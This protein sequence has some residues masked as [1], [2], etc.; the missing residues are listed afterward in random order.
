MARIES[1]WEIVDVKP[2]NDA[3]TSV[4]FRHIEG[5]EITTWQAGQYMTLQVLQDTQWSAAHP[6]TITAPPGEA[7]L[8]A[9]I[10]NVGSFSARMQQVTSGTPARIAGPFGKFCSN[11][12]VKPNIAMIAGGIG[13]TPFLSVL[14]HFRNIH[15]TNT[16]TLFW[17]NNLEQDLFAVDELRELAACLNLTLVF[18]IL[19]RSE[20]AVLGTVQPPLYLEPGYLTADILKKYVTCSDVSLYL[21]GSKNMQDFVQAQLLQCGIAA[22]N[23]EKEAFG[24]YMKAS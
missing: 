14:R 16:V 22:D 17:A 6:F 18:V 9:T 21:C 15:A 20:Q 5:P 10:K 8:R 2:E 1:L 12:H 4:F 13:I 7:L 19:N 24:V 11:I 3:V 23:V